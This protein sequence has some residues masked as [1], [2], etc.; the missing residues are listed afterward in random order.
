MSAV[1]APFVHMARHLFSNISA[2]PERLFTVAASVRWLRTGP[3]GVAHA[4]RGIAE[5]FG[6]VTRGMD[7]N[8][9]MPRCSAPHVQLLS[10]EHES[11][12]STVSSELLWPVHTAVQACVPHSSE[13][14]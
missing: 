8:K 3:V 13:P 1:P 14:P 5:T 4:G 9:A 7:G 2:S 10:H 11:P 6:L 12:H